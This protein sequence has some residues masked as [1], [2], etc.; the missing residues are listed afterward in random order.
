MALEVVCVLYVNNINK[1]VRLL[2]KT[3]IVIIKI[4]KSNI[5]YYQNKGYVT[6]QLK[7]EISVGLQDLP[8]GSHA[9]IEAVCDKCGNMKDMEYR[10]Y[11]KITKRDGIYYCKKCCG[12]KI[13]ETCIERYGGVGL[14]AES[15]KEKAQNTNLIRYG[16]KTPFENKEIYAKIRKSQEDKYGG[17]GMASQQTRKKIEDTNMKLRGVKNP[18]QSEEVKEKKAQTC[19]EHYGVRHIFQDYDRFCEIMKKREKTFVKNGTTPMSKPER[20]IVAQLERLFGK[21]NCTPS[22]LFAPLTF[23]CL[24]K[25]DDVKIDVEYDGWFWHRITQEKDRRRNHTVINAGY[26]V[27]RIKSLREMPTDEQIIEAVEYLTTTDHHYKEIIL[28]I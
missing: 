13:K 12:Q 14:Q 5:E 8:D 9:K 10:T 15:I 19:F 2:I 28:D 6:A 23:D 17:I 21:E 16:C 7:D 4:T 18:S 24:L 26:K 11:L 27:L 3:K 1:E 20:E 22:Y 25:L